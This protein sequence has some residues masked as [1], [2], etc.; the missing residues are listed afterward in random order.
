MAISV[1]PLQEISKGTVS[2]ARYILRHGSFVSNS[3]T[4]LIIL[5]S[6]SKGSYLIPSSTI[7]PTSCA[8]LGNLCQGKKPRSFS[9]FHLWEISV[10]LG[11]FIHFFGFVFVSERVNC[12]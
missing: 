5:L 9:Q 6:L 1:L 12:N 3:Q 4:F 8:N 10:F 11:S 7:E 2:L